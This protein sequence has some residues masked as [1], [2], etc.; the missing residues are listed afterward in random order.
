MHLHHVVVFVGDADRSLAFYREGLGLETLVDK[1]FDGDWPVIFGTGTER[2]RAMILGDPSHPERGQVE[3]LTFSDPVANGPG[4]APPAT[5]FVMLSFMVDLAT[6]LPRLEAAGG[7][8][9]RRMSLRN[10]TTVVTL[11]DPD[12]VL[13]ELLDVGPGTA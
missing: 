7:T 10:G 5:G 4:A 11:R 3:L 8:D 9:V 1:E 13:V 2:L 12:G 6:V